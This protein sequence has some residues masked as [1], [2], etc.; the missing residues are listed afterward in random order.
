MDL[1][2]IE[3]RVEEVIREAKLAGWTTLSET[4]KAALFRM[5][6]EAIEV[7]AREYELTQYDPEARE[8]TAMNI[9]RHLIKEE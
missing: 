7:G 1:I 9:R 8:R 2:V 3:A 4:V 5:W 6:N